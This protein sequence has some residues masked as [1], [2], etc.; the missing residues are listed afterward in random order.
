MA[1]RE[2][3][4]C[5]HCNGWFDQD[6][7]ASEDGEHLAGEQ[8]GIMGK[9]LAAIQTLDKA[10]QVARDEY[11]KADEGSYMDALPPLSKVMAAL[12]IGDELDG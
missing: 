12:G 10:R 4:W 11:R 7:Y 5:E 1:D 8:Y 3:H 9:G 6:H 2:Q